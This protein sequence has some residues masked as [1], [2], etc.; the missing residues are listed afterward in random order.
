[1]TWYCFKRPVTGC[2]DILPP[3]KDATSNFEAIGHSADARELRKK[4]QIGI[5]A[6]VS[7]QSPVARVG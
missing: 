3:A 5:V 4:Y 1:M 7:H 6:K 2:C